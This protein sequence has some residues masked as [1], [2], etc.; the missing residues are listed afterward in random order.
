MQTNAV[1]AS[2]ATASSSVSEARYT[3]RDA[4]MKTDSETEL[5]KLVQIPIAGAITLLFVAE[6]LLIGAPPQAGEPTPH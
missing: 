1:A 4:F 3:K 5:L 6:R 2:N